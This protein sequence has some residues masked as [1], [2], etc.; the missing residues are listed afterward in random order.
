MGWGMG[1]AGSFLSAEQSMGILVLSPTR[2]ALPVPLKGFFGITMAPFAF[3][4]HPHP[5]S[6]GNW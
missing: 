1:Q 2:H 3:H 6:L 5:G 4:R